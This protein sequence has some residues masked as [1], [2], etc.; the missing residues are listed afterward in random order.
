MKAVPVRCVNRCYLMLVD[1]EVFRVD[2]FSFQELF[3]PNAIVA[4]VPHMYNGCF[5]SR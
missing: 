2:G 3:Q 4:D 1:S 5:C